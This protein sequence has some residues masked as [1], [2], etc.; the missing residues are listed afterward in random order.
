MDQNFLSVWTNMKQKSVWNFQ[1]SQN[2]YYLKI[3]SSSDNLQQ[4]DW[5]EFAGAI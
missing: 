4:I 3:K 1:I 2:F 5:S